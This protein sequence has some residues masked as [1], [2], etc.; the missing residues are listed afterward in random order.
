MYMSHDPGCCEGSI[1]IDIHVYILY[2]SHVLCSCE[3]S[4]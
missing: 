3:G 1:D 4:I 2:M